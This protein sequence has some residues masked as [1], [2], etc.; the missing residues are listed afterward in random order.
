[1]YRCLCCERKFDKTE[2]ILDSMEE[3]FGFPAP[4]YYDGCPYCKEWDV[5]E[6]IGECCECGKE[7]LADDRYDYENGDL[8]CRDCHNKWEEEQ[9]EEEE[10]VPEKE[11]V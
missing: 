2:K 10:D 11:A 9:C 7:L 5:A 8:F 6:I 1:M 4:R 3:W